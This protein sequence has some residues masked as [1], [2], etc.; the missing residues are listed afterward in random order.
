MKNLKIIG[1]G[2][3]KGNKI[4]QF[5]NNIR[6]R[7]DETQSH[8]TMSVNAVEQAL[9]VAECTIDDMDLIVYASAVGYQPI[10]CSASLI[11]EK[12][13]PKKPIP[14][15]DINTTCTSFITA[16]DTISYMVHDGRYNRVLILSA[17]TASLGINPDQ[18]ESYELFS[19]GAAAIIV[20]K[21]ETAESG[22]MFGM[23]QT[24]TQGAHNTEIRG[25][26]SSLH[27]RHYTKENKAEYLFDMNGPKI[28]RLV[29]KKIPEFVQQLEKEIGMTLGDIDL[30][31]PHQASRALPVI[32]KKLGVKEGKYMNHV[33]EYGNMIAASVPYLLCL[34][35]EENRIKKGNTVLLFGTAA[36]LTISGLLIKI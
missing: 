22:V 26:L 29:A 10:P 31:I 16:L 12:F 5:D 17:E 20:E 23:W 35:L 13:E 30:I 27:P 25:G 9:L 28:L 33:E 2:K 32:M 7:M 14:C 3:D 8:Y 21:D 6:H 19:D 15:M 24:W 11:L 18:K 1:Y 36:G 34:A 4:I